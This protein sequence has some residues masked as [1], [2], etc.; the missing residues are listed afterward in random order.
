M[1]STSVGIFWIDFLCRPAFKG[2]MKSPELCL[3]LVLLTYACIA[4]ALVK[5]AY[6]SQI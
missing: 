6:T 5:S 3:V 1:I 4:Y 2:I